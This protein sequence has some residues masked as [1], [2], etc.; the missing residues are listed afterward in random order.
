MLNSGIVKLLLGKLEQD[1]IDSLESFKRQW[2]IYAREGSVF[3]APPDRNDNRFGLVIEN[4]IV[5]RVIAG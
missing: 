4:G 5:I 1:A 2:R 3:D